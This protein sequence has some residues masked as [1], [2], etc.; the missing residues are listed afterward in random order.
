MPEFRSPLGNKQ[1]QGQPMRD[2]AVPDE[3]GQ[4]P[5][6]AQRMRHGR[7]HPDEPVFDERAM[8]ELQAQMEPQYTPPHA[9]TPPMREL[10]EV[11]QQILNA[12]RARREGKE[13]LS[14]GARKR[15]EMLI[16]MTRMTREVDIEGQLYV[17]KTLTSEELRD[18]MTATA[19]FDGSVQFIFETRRQLLAR[20]LTMIAG[21][22]IDQFLNSY[23]L[24]D[25]L[26]MI[27]KLDHA[28]LMRLYNE[29]T[30]L[31]G[32]AQA[33]YSPKTDAQVK[34]VLED[35]KK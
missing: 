18:A 23:D 1:I 33:R 17:L 21:V 11:E 10:S 2:I 3:T 19:E 13:R 15:I 30:S 22:D 24:E 6:P 9:Q 7:A 5:G 31:A 26:Y 12:K 28:L 8:R 35:L 14:D 29:Y 34:E 32:E 4:Q 16:G 20:S 27:E 25:R